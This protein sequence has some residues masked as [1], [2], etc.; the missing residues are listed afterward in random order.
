MDLTSTRETKPSKSTSSYSKTKDG[1]LMQLK[2]QGPELHRR[3]FLTRRDLRHG[4]ISV[5]DASHFGVDLL[6]LHLR[7]SA[8]KFLMAADLCGKT[9]YLKQPLMIESDQ[10]HQYGQ[11]IEIYAFGAAQSI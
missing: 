6:D 9:I 1:V 3:A 8:P 11:L 4:L 5:N 10:I 7:C 2:I